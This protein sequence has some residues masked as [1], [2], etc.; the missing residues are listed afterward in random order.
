DTKSSSTRSSCTSLMGPQA[1]AE[2]IAAS[3][4]GVTVTG[5]TLA[6]SIPGQAQVS[7]YDILGGKA[8]D[9]TVSGEGSLSL[10]SLSRGIYIY[11]VRGEAIRQSGKLVI[12]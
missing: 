1:G 3:A 12:R 4:S 7:I 10:A 9:T 2:S 8:V 6:Y 11:M 5:N